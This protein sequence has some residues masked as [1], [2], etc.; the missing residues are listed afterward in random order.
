VPEDE[1]PTLVTGDS[2]LKEGMEEAEKLLSGPFMKITSVDQLKR[3]GEMAVKRKEGFDSAI[4]AKMNFKRA[5]RIRQLRVELNCTWRSVAA[6]SHEDWGEDACWDPES[7][8]LAGM[9]LC[10]YAA[11]FLGEDAKNEP[12]N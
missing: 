1:K 12:W 8:Q 2:A 3:L 5:V 4:A 7:N 9:S 11:K 6:H 10:E